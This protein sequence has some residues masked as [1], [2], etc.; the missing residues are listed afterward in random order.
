MRPSPLSAQ[1]SLT[2]TD[3]FKLNLLI[4][5]LTENYHD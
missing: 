3:Y 2:F 1:T 4:A 5:I